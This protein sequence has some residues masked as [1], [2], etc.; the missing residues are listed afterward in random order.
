[1]GISS[2]HAAILYIPGSSSAYN[3]CTWCYWLRNDD[4]DFRYRVRSLEWLPMIAPRIQTWFD[5]QGPLPEV[6]GEKGGEGD[7]DNI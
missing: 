4:N 7:D 5:A 1:M 6:A 2:G 3:L